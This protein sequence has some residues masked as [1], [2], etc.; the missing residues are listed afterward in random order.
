M[1]F[2]VYGLVECTCKLLH[3][4][5]QDL[6]TFTI[7]FETFCKRLS[8]SLNHSLTCKNHVIH[9][10]VLEDINFA[11][12]LIILLQDILICFINFF[13]ISLNRTLQGFNFISLHLLKLLSLQ[14]V[15]LSC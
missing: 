1:T 14:I 15:L 12:G 8:F 9:D 6:L 5:D 13:S 7:H 3:G 4:M 2:L 11:S 10:L